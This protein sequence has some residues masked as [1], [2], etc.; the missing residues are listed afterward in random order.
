MAPTVHLERSPYFQQVIA[1]FNTVVGRSRLMRLGPKSQVSRHVDIHYY[2]RQRVRIHVPIVTYPDVI[3]NCGEESVHMAAGEAWIFDNWRYHEV[4]NP[5][6]HNRVHLVIDTCGSADF[7]SL[8]KQSDET[9]VKYE[10]DSDHQLR[11][12]TLEFPKLLSPSEI[13]VDFRMI[14]DEINAYLDNDQETKAALFD[15]MRDFRRDWRAMYLADRD[16][17]SGIAAGLN[18]VR[19]LRTASSPIAEKLKLAGNGAEAKAALQF[20]LDTA[21]DENV[22]RNLDKRL[23]S[24][25]TLHSPAVVKSNQTSKFDE[26]LYDRPVFIVAAPRSGSTLL[27]ETLAEHEI[28]WTIG[29]EAHSHIEKIQALHP[30][31]H[32]F[33]SNILTAEDATPET[34]DSIYRSFGVALRDIDGAMIM[35]MALSERPRTIRFLEKTPK[36]ALRI[37]FFKKIFPNARFIYLH[38]EIGSNASSILEA[39]RSRRFV[40]YPRLPGWINEPWSLVLFPGWRDL[41]NASVAEIAVQQWATVNKV[42]LEDL[43]ALPRADWTSVS[44]EA[45]LANPVEE[46]RRLLEFCDLPFTERMSSV[47]STELKPSQYTLTKP[48][49]NKWLKNKDELEPYFAAA[50]DIEAAIRDIDNDAKTV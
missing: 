8:L 18:L 16:T 37:P 34:A 1:H 21:V 10:P 49:P 44:N 42:I 5:T 4:D 48:E 38:R 3:F 23:E 2:W 19:K 32:K 20:T 39:W 24:G 6:D 27:Y 28:F 7:W 31:S 22:A 45:F 50:A 11:V 26:K 29:G 15:L 14:E 36:N 33:S 30:A 46:T 41:K 12:E 25:E 43:T 13:D 9:F 47:V 40:T 35:R 17:D